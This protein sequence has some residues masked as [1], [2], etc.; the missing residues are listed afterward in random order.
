MEHD[1]P[2]DIQDE[3]SHDP[4][5]NGEGIRVTNPLNAST[6][7]QNSLYT[8]ENSH[9]SAHHARQNLHRFSVYRAKLLDRLR[10]CQL[11]STLGDSRANAPSPPFEEA[12]SASGVWA[13]YLNESGNYNTDMVAEQRGE[14]NILLVFAGLF[15]AVVTA[16]IV[17]SS[18]NLEPNYQQMSALLLF[19]Q[20][21]IQRGLANGTSI[22]DIT[23]SGTDPSAPFTLDPIDWFVNV[24]WFMSLTLSLVAAFFTM[25]VDA[26]YCH[27][28]GLIIWGIRFSIIILQFLLHTSLVTFLYGLVL[29]TGE[30]LGVLFSCFMEVSTIL[31]VLF[32]S[33]SSLIP[34]VKPECLWTTPLTYIFCAIV[35]LLRSITTVQKTISS[36]EVQKPSAANGLQVSETAVV[37]KSHIENEVDAL[38]WLYERSPTSAIHR[39][40]IQALSGLPPDYIA[41]A[42]VF[43]SPHWEEIREEKERMLMDCMELIRDGSTRWIP[44][45]ILNID[46]RIEPLLRL[47]ILFPALRRKFPTGLFEEHDLDFLTKDISDTLLITLSSIDDPHI[48]KPKKQMQVVL[49]ALTNN[50]LH[51]PLVW[52]NVLDCS[53]V[54]KRLFDNPGNFLTDEMCRRLL[55]EIYSRS[56]TPSASCSCTL[57]HTSVKYFEPKLLRSLL[58]LFKK[59]R[60]RGDN[61]YLK[62]TLLEETIRYFQWAIQLSNHSKI[63]RSQLQHSSVHTMEDRTYYIAPPS[64]KTHRT[65]VFQD[66]LS[67]IASP[68]FRD[69]KSSYKSWRCCAWALE[70]MACFVEMGPKYCDVGPPAEWAKRPFWSNILG[71]IVNEFSSNESYVTAD[72]HYTEHCESVKGA[73]SSLLGHTFSL[74]V[75]DTYETFREKAGFGDIA[76]R[77]KLHPEFIKVMRGYITGISEAEMG[78]LPEDQSDD[79]LDWHIQDLHQ[80][81]VIGFICTTI[82]YSDA[83]RHRILS[84]LISI[85]PNHSE[86][87]GIVKTLSEN[88]E[89]SFE[90]Y[91][92]GR[93]ML[94]DDQERLEESMK[95]TVRVLAEC[96]EAERHHRNGINWLPKIFNYQTSSAETR[97][98]S[99]LRKGKERVQ[100]PEGGH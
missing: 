25:L 76:V 49:D 71:D 89:Y 37:E 64:L 46:S 82:T 57:A 96:L 22:D 36:L 30:N 83:P 86:W 80:V 43:F 34:L 59:P 66:I 26:W 79:F 91:I 1:M 51:H 55:I 58:S 28:L 19:D 27:Y 98:E 50:G 31:T 29:Y 74:R 70:C 24:L 78:K 97:R 40:V 45:D 5:F 7:T 61:N 81:H 32:Y 87:D 14:V 18:P 69:S 93:D 9:R 10:E 60:S 68:L 52:K 2:S 17:L 23:T 53:T 12:G 100:D 73:V 38:R 44:K 6:P 41:Y 33:I 63:S 94:P 35:R 54:Q 3:I 11:V 90:K 77:K 65:E 48:R 85:Q 15:S 75:K 8:P 95:A 88:D 16:F 84:S 67:Y 39:L 99:R 42:E 47:E 92:L 21:N 4:V 56:N 13:A 62:S 72:T 20:I